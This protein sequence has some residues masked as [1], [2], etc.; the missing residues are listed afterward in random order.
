VLRP[1]GS[2]AAG[3][4]LA[5]TLD[6]HVLYYP[7]HA[8]RSQP[9]AYVSGR[10]RTAASAVANASGC[11]YLPY[12][13]RTSR[14]SVEVRATT[15]DGL[16]AQLGV[17]L[18]REPVALADLVLAE[19]ERLHVR[20]VDLAGAPVAGVTVVDR[21]TGRAYPGTTDAAGVLA[22]AAPRLPATP[23]AR[24]D[25]W[26][27]RE[28]RHDGV[29]VDLAAPVESCA[30][31]VELVLAPAPG[32][33]LRVVDAETGM[34]VN[35][36][37]GRVDLVHAGV[38]TGSSSFEMDRTGSARL[39]FFDDEQ[40]PDGELPELVRIHYEREGYV[41]GLLELDP[42]LV[43][44]DEVLELALSPDPAFPCLRGRV[45]RAG[46]PVAGLQVGLQAQLRADGA[47]PRTWQ[48]TR[49]YTDA[50]GRFA[51]R[52]RA[53]PGLVVTAFPHWFEYAEFG[54]IGPLDGARAV[55]GEHVL[56]LLPAVRVPALLRG[57]AAE[58]VYS[59]YVHVL[60]ADG[61]VAASTTINGAPLQLAG[62]GEV[63]TS[64]TLPSHRRVSVT[65]GF[66][67]D[68]SVISGGS[69]PV[70]H[71]PA[72]PVLP[73]VFDVRPLFARVSGRVAGVAPDELGRCGV[74]FVQ[75]YEQT[76]RL[77]EVAGEGSFELA[78]LPLGKGALYLV[79]AGERGASDASVVL[80]C[81][82]LE[83]TG[84][85]EGLVVTP[86]PASLPEEPDER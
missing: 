65:I 45:L 60:D 7:R 22:L 11:F 55:E 25:G 48:Y 8:T 79:R 33:S 19:P 2:P 39:R 83:L 3:A 26:W 21:G 56:E 54:F 84:A 59:Y 41:D 78:R 66:R 64:L 75:A 72:H 71:D 46:A 13:T 28:R 31:R 49:G 70:E 42:R 57:V 51:L 37:H 16:F 82:E 5:L 68:S 53:A 69:P 43:G 67:T 63:R 35:L 80:A 86:D 73:L 44:P 23:F 34:T 76:A 50:D 62:S 15:E 10:S 4:A 1:D 14:A 9:H 17:E 36:G 74:A 20:A 52:W 32:A 38:F 24:A 81:V 58:G 30:T 18:P 77:A 61:A 47:A 12:A 40:E 27:Q 6:E 85:R 29:A